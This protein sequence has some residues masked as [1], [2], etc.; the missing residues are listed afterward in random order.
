MMKRDAVKCSA[1]KCRMTKKLNKVEQVIGNCVRFSP[2]L[3]Q[4][5]VKFILKANQANAQASQAN[6]AKM[7]YPAYP[8]N[9][10]TSGDA[11]QSIN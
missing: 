10:T 3:H 7:G 6:R 11:Y 5:A 4:F 2:M 9:T 8:C 1:T